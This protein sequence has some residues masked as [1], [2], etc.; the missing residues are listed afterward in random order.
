MK[1]KNTFIKLK[2]VKPGTKILLPIGKT[3]SIFKSLSNKRK[4]AKF[5]EAVVGSNNSYSYNGKHIFVKEELKK[6]YS[7]VI[8]ASNRKTYGLTPDFKFKYSP[9][10]S[11]FNVRP[12]IAAEQ[13]PS[14]QAPFALLAGLIGL[15]ALAA[16]TNKGKEVSL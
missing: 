13:K 12:F 1:Q 15:G 6:D 4:P 3:G 7:D 9:Y 2:D 14:S 10:N 5:I 8:S 16:S 11:N